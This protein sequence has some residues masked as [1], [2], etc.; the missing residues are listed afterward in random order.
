MAGKR[1]KTI[2]IFLIVLDVIA[3][4]AFA[5]FLVKTITTA[6]KV[7]S[8]FDA[9]CAGQGAEDA[10]SYVPWVIG[11][12]FAASIILTLAILWFRLRPAAAGPKSWDEVAQMGG[13]AATAPQGWQSS[14]AIP[15][16]GPAVTQVSSADFALPGQGPTWSPTV[17]TAAQASIVATRTVN[18]TPTGMEMQIDMDVM[19][20]GQATRRVTKQMTVPP[21]SLARLYPGAVVPVMVNPGDPGDVTPMLSG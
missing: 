13:T 14:A 8:C 7:T 18:S 5:Y 21:G 16:Y 2:G 12:A 20:P 19:A 11:T 9:S 17:T 4:G 3:W 6:T 1:S 15:G 10:A